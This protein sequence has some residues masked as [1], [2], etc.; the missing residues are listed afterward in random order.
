M[1]STRHQLMIAPKME[2]PLDFYQAWVL[3]DQDIFNK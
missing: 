1:D 3:D 2:N